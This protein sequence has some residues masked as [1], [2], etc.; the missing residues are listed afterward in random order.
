[1]SDPEAVYV[2]RNPPRAPSTSAPAARW[3][4]APPAPPPTSTPSPSTSPRGRGD[5]DEL[6]PWRPRQAS[7]QG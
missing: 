2:E 5:L 7:I 3:P 6:V 4:A 1:M